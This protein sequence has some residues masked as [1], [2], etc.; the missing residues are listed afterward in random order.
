[1]RA[2]DALGIIVGLLGTVLGARLA[3]SLLIPALR[4]QNRD[5]PLANI[6]VLSLSSLVV[7]ALCIALSY[8]LVVPIMSLSLFSTLFRGAILG[9]VLSLAL[10][11]PALRKRVR[12]SL[13][14]KSVAVL[15]L[16]SLAAGAQY[17]IFVKLAKFWISFTLVTSLTLAANYVDNEARLASHTN[18]IYLCEL[19]PSKYADACARSEQSRFVFGDSAFADVARIRN[20]AIYLITYVGCTLVVVAINRLD[21]KDP[22]STPTVS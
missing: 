21:R 9:A 17:I 14:G 10:F 20:P 4:K 22:P 6:V 5:S 2:L 7:G 1:M 15:S 12:D 19:E 8:Q 3:Q 13:L 16:G 11:I 18:D